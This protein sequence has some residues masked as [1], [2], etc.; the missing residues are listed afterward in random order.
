MFRAYYS[1]KDKSSC[2]RLE[3]PWRLGTGCCPNIRGAGAENA[4]LRRPTQLLS[5]PFKNMRVSLR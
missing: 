4:D 1:V 3:R 5:F 2:L